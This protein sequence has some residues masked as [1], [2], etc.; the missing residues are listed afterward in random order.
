MWVCKPAFEIFSKAASHPSH[1][2]PAAAEAPGLPSPRISEPLPLDPECGEASSDTRPPHTGPTGWIHALPHRSLF[3]FQLNTRTS[4]LT[5]PTIV[6]RPQRAYDHPTGTGVLIK[7]PNLS[8]APNPD[9]K[10]L[11]RQEVR[12]WLGVKPSAANKDPPASSIVHDGERRD[13]VSNPGGIWTRVSSIKA[14]T[15]DLQWSQRLSVLESYP[16]RIC[17]KLHRTLQSRKRKRRGNSEFIYTYV[18]M[19]SD[20]TLPALIAIQTICGTGGL[21]QLSMWRETSTR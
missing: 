20:I 16:G 13:P 21:E 5:V 15:L 7:F 4:L 1:P 2:P 3:P 18:C 10:V 8:S 6:E 17:S 11:V 9:P 19:F 12:L 14:C